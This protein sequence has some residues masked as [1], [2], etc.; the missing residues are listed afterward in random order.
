MWYIMLANTHLLTITTSNKPHAPKKKA[1]AEISMKIFNK[2]SIGNK[3]TS[4]VIVL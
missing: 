2:N 1:K 4:M 3:I